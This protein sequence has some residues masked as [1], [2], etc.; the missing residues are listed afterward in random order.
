MLSSSPFLPCAQPRHA[1]THTHTHL[2]IAH[3]H[4]YPPLL[5]TG[6][7]ARVTE[8]TL[9]AP[10]PTIGVRPSSVR[11]SSFLIPSAVLSTSAQRRVLSTA[12]PRARG[13]LAAPHTTRCRQLASK[14]GLG[15]RAARAPSATLRSTSSHL[16]CCAGDRGL[17][18]G[19]M[20]DPYNLY[21]RARVSSGRK[22]LTPA[23]HTLTGRG[24]C[25]TSADG[26]LTPSS[27]MPSYVAPLCVETRASLI[28]RPARRPPASP[29]PLLWG[30]ESFY[31]RPAIYTAREPPLPHCKKDAMQTAPCSLTI[32]VTQYAILLLFC[33]LYSSFA[34]AYHNRTLGGSG[35]RGC[36]PRSRLQLFY[37]YYSH[38]KS[39]KRTVIKLVAKGGQV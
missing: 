26:C 31:L 4:G 15:P 3:L 2:D 13:S 17:K 12:R 39:L 7:T 14:L 32:H 20:I 16:D 10:A 22:A 21:T 25:A 29:P 1:R 6:Q 33:Y 38:T 9:C 28:T 30:W 36:S 34:S 5:R 11:L 24:A 19:F 8:L 23:T 37:N 18:K 27:L 35:R